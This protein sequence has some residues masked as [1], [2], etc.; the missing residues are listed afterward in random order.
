MLNRNWRSKSL[1][2]NYNIHDVTFL[3]NQRRIINFKE[4]E[5]SNKS[6]IN[7]FTRQVQFR[8]DVLKRIVD[9]VKV[10]EKCGLSYRGNKRNEAIF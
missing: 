10:T 1:K 7:A 8:R 9:V 3:L 2:L 6:E 5:V 4:N